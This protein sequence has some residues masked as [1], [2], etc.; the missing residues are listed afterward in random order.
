M[1]PRSIRRCQANRPLFAATHSNRCG[2]PQISVAGAQERKLPPLASCPTAPTAGRGGAAWERVG[3]LVQLAE[4]Q[5]D[6]MGAAV[7]LELG[8]NP[9]PVVLD[10]PLAQA[11]PVSRFTVLHPLRGA[12]DNQDL[13]SRQSEDQVRGTSEESPTHCTSTNPR[14]VP[15]LRTSLT[16]NDPREHQ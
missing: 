13:S 1:V 15:R 12:D 4:Q 6:R 10:R 7:G 9:C 3:N 2:Y 5:A 16:L 11:E 14:K 8:A